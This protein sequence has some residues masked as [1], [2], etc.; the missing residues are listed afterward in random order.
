MQKERFIRI[1][2]KGEWKGEEHKSSAVLPEDEGGIAEGGISCYS[3]DRWGKAD[4]IER[5]RWYF[6]N[7]VMDTNPEDYSSRQITIFD[8][9]KVGEGSEYE[10]IARCEITLAEIEAKPIMEQIFD[11]YDRYYIDEELTKD[12][13]FAELEKI[14]LEV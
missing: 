2:W 5:L 4:A 12:E 11:L 13:Y 8:G 3:I 7:I 10:D 1:D 6:A 9:Y 14:D